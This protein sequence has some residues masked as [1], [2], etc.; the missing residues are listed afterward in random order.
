MIKSLS[1]IIPFFNEQKRIGGN[2]IKIKQFIKNNYKINYE[3]IFVDDG[4]TDNSKKKF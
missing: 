2:L 4:S 1:I 3:I